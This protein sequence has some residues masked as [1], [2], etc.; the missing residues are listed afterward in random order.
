MPDTEGLKITPS[1]KQYLFWKEKYPDCLLFFRMGDFYEMFFED[2]KI[3]SSV[4]DLV[5]TSRSKD[6]NAIPM[7]GIPFHAVNSYLGRLIA[8]GYRVAICEQTSEPNGRDLVEREVTR[9]VTPGTW[10]PD[11]SD[12]E[13]RIAAVYADGKTV[14]LALLVSG[15]G[16]LHA[17][18]FA[19]D[20][21]IST[22]MSFR[23]DEILVRKGTAE[24]IKKYCG[25]LLPASISERERGEFDA[26][27]GSRWLCKKWELATL[28]AM[29]FDDRDSAVG[30]AAAALRYLEE[31][32]FS[33]AGHV[34]SV[35]PILPSQNMILD[36][37]T[38]LNLELVEPAGTSL[39]SILNRCRTPMGKR[40][41]K[42][43]ILAPLQDIDEIK[44][45]QS[46]VGLLAG[47]RKLSSELE[48]SL[49]ECR[50]IARSIG[51]LT[52]KMASPL[53]LAAIRNTLN[54]LPEIRAAVHKT[55]LED[56]IAVPD[57]SDLSH[58]L[59]V[60]LAEVPP[61]ML[62]DGGVIAPGYNAELD[63][64]RNMSVDSSNWLKEFEARESE[65]TGIKTLKCG[66]NKVFGYYIEIP[67][68]GLDR[69]PAEYVRKQTL[70]NG[71]RFITEELKNF[72]RDMFRAG[73][74]IAA[75][76]DRLYNS[77]LLSALAKS[78]ELQTIGRYLSLLD[79]FQSLARVAR[80]GRYVCPEMDRNCDFIVKGGRHPVIE[81]ALGRLPFTPN[82]ISFSSEKGQRIAI[83][84]GPNMAGKSTYL[85]MA[86]LLA[87]MAHIGSWLPAEKA[88]IGIIDRVFTRI[89]ARDELARGQST[90]MVEMV[91]TANI[92]RH[93]T[94]KSL[95]ILDEVGRGT[96]TYDGLSIAWSV[97][98]YLHGQEARQARVLFATHYHELTKL[99]GLLSGVVNLSMAVEEK[100]DGIIFLHKI[101]TMPADRSYGIEVAKLAGVPASVLRRSRELLQQ[102]EEDASA[103]EL[104]EAVNHNQMTLFDI[105]QEAVLEEIANLQP[106]ELTPMQALQLLYKLKKASREALNL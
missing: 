6:E 65:R 32:Q 47:D 4:L 72:E 20:A 25:N 11:D 43:W 91:E 35:T 46:S 38:Q 1:M 97:I 84:T 88:R 12:S 42:E 48:A 27:S 104:S 100:N 55:E 68:T 2:A 69:V 76:E 37:S 9:V 50:D 62:R 15:T 22:L 45:R 39:F 10:L 82:D 103:K 49:S 40:L 21:A 23:P 92:L 74:E 52:L 56:W 90:F 101:I 26:A 41:L 75:I 86:A 24:D 98:E 13:G 60:A 80:E 81:A 94:D 33:K 71:E 18:T 87:I 93:A 79:V 53:D 78:S 7:A 36:Q 95:V 99:A 14:S 19:R 96:S 67:N 17:A 85:R 3:A 73:E 77:L 34:R 61:R 51:R 44:R 8:A 30:C 66:V 83:I 28:K 58:L 106:D 102:F 29:G 16:T 63:H 89:G 54:K 59:N 57:V 31:T 105:K 5:L 70:V 64:W